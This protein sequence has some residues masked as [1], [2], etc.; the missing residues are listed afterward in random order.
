MNQSTN[1]YIYRQINHWR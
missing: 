1:D